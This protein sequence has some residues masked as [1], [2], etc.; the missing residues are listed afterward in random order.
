MEKDLQK[1]LFTPKDIKKFSG[2][3]INLNNP[4]KSLLNRRNKLIIFI[5]S[6]LIFWLVSAILLILEYLGFIIAKLVVN[7][8][9]GVFVY[10]LLGITGF[11]SSYGLLPLYIF[12]SL[13]L[14][15]FFNNSFPS[16]IDSFLS[17]IPAPHY[18]Y[19][20][21]T[22]LVCIYISSTIISGI[23]VYAIFSYKEDDYYFNFQK[24]R[25]SKLLSIINLIVEYNKKLSSIQINNNLDDINENEMMEIINEKNKVISIYQFL[26]EDLIN[27][28]KLERIIRE[29]AQENQNIE[30]DKIFTKKAFDYNKNL[31]QEEKLELS[32]TVNDAINFSINLSRKIT[33]LKA[34]LQ[35]ILFN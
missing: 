9:H 17:F 1:L 33:E 19:L 21:I 10:L 35:K 18:E 12:I 7:L 16:Y 20:G 13:I 28:L 22:N 6:F 3:V 11:F 31:K 23:V 29:N 25:Y 4:V 8:F 24:S 15:L 30:Q 26:K 27:L 34:D 5:K 2:V 32:V 14:Y